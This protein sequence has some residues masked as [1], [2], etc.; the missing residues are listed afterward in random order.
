M[1][2]I[3]ATG[4]AVSNR[5]SLTESWVQRGADINGLELSSDGYQFG[6]AVALTPDGTTFAASAP[7][8]GTANAGHVRVFDW[9]G[10]VWVQ[11]GDN[12]TGG[13][14]DLSGS[15]PNQLAI[16]DGGLVLAVGAA[17]NDDGNNDAG[18]VK[19]YAWSGG[20]WAQRGADL[21]GAGYDEYFGKSV[22]L[23]ADGGVLAVGA[24]GWG[25]YGT[26][27]QDSGRTV[28]YAWSGSAYV[29][30]GSDI[31]GG[32]KYDGSGRDVALSSDGTV[33]A[34]SALDAD[35]IAGGAHY[36]VGHVRVF[37]WSGSVWAQ[38]GDD[39]NGETAGDQDGMSIGLSDD[40]ETL[41]V[42]SWKGNLHLL[43][44]AQLFAHFLSLLC[45][46]R[47]ARGRPARARGSAACSTGA[48]RRGASVA[49]TSKAR[50]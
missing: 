10:S 29:Q 25:Q 9:S 40:G 26:N 37:K 12:I 45:M 32:D 34:T 47:W 24:T 48:G 19:V 14:A 7:G 15:A 11:R 4:F 23:S 20:A 1:L 35:Y 2:I 17:H 33:L 39:I 49:P 28:V 46:V 22:A 30:R 18:Q 41:A 36:D 31:P 21:N 42:G 44:F 13:D 50:T 43:S 5:R 27:S 38:R 6:T 3:L 16:S 8:A